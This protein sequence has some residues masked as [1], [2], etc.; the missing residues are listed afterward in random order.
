MPL[1]S[2]LMVLGPCQTPF[3]PSGLDQTPS[4]RGWFKPLSPPLLPPCPWLGWDHV[5]LPLPHGA[6]LGLGYPH[7]LQAV[8]TPIPGARS[9]PLARFGLWADLA[10][11][12]WLARL[13][14]GASLF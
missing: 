7:A 2:P 13:K 4:P 5:K 12:I 6:R 14:G 1:S 8:S 11:A 3:P 10:L 9:G